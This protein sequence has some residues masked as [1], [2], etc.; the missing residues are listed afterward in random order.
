[1]YRMLKLEVQELT[2]P[3]TASVKRM[4]NGHWMMGGPRIVGR[5]KSEKS[6]DGIEPNNKARHRNRDTIH[7]KKNVGR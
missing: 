1:M 5:R 6:G 7:L 4:K 3:R 2:G